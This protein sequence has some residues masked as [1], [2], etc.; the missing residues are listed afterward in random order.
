MDVHETIVK[1]IISEDSIAQAKKQRYTFEVHISA[2]K[3]AIKKAIEK[4]FG[5]IV[6]K[7]NTIIVKGKTRRYGRKKKEIILG[8]R[9]KALIEIT[10]GQKI[11]IFGTEEQK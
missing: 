7:V 10:K 8:Q 9:K 11:D 5:V 3:P 2:D 4:L 6:V 1:P